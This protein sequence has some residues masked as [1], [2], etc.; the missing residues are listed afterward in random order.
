MAGS[1]R[2]C[3][4]IHHSM[5]MCHHVSQFIS[6][7][8]PAE[9]QNQVNA[10]LPCYQAGTARIASHSATDFHTVFKT[11]LPETFSPAL[12]LLARH[13]RDN[14]ISVSSF[15]LPYIFHATRHPG[16]FFACQAA[17]DM[18]T[19]TPERAWLCLT[20]TSTALPPDLVGFLLDYH[21]GSSWP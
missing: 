17:C 11:R 18:Q 1:P 4:N 7:F 2:F 14:V 20:S 8:L 16:F 9:Q 5:K 6:V 10:R 21:N 3:V 13:A 12:R 19:I 15:R